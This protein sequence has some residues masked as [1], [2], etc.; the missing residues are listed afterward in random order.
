[1]KKQHF[2]LRLMCFSVVQNA[3]WKHDNSRM[4]FWTT[5]S[6][7]NNW[8][9]LFHCHMIYLWRLFLIKR[10]SW[11]K[12]PVCSRSV[13]WTIMRSNGFSYGHEENS[14]SSIIHFLSLS[15]SLVLLLCCIGTYVYTCIATL[16][17][18]IQQHI[19]LLVFVHMYVSWGPTCWNSNFQ[20]IWHV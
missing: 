11:S 19:Y 17:P 6:N 5:S 16:L 7:N 15:F 9:I 1:M 14:W 2:F 13:A 18:I 12:Y 3:V 8:Q 20:S 10:L 4:T